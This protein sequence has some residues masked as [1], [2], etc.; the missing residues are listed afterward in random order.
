M[1][2]PV[3][4]ACVVAT[5]LL[6]RLW[7]SSHALHRAARHAGPEAA[8][9]LVAANSSLRR[10][11]DRAYDTA[12]KLSDRAA[13]MD[14]AHE[15]SWGELVF[16][17]AVGAL[18]G[19]CWGYTAWYVGHATMGGDNV[20]VAVFAIGF[21]AL[22]IGAHLS[23]TARKASRPG[24]LEKVGEASARLLKRAAAVLGTAAAIFTT[25]K[26][27]P[28]MPDWG[29]L[30]SIILCELA[31]ALML[32]AIGTQVITRG[33]GP[34]LR[35]RAAGEQRL[36][37][38]LS[39]TMHILAVTLKSSTTEL[40]PTVDL[41]GG[42]SATTSALPPSSPQLRKVLNDDTQAIP[43][44]ES[45]DPGQAEPPDS[46]DGLPYRRVSGLVI[47]AGLGFAAAA[48]LAGSGDA[49]ASEAHVSIR[50][51][52]TASV[53]RPEAAAAVTIIDEHVVA[54]ARESQA[55]TTITLGAWS[56]GS[57]EARSVGDEWIVP[58]FEFTCSSPFRIRCEYLRQ[59]ARQHADSLRAPVIQ[60]FEAAMRD[61]RQRLAFELD[62]S[63]GSSIASLLSSADR[64]AEAGLSIVV[65]DGEQQ[66]YRAPIPICHS[67]GRVVVILVGCR[68]D[69]DGD[70]AARADALRRLGYVVANGLG[71]ARAL[72]WASLLA[73]AAR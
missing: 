44:N 8:R 57:L 17:C 70:G 50:F 30:G 33:P 71:E 36:A 68:F 12:Q 52:T 10:R 19:G 64:D 13:A 39:D 69:R 55:T 32:A 54:G 60:Q 45:R 61:L 11:R 16:W 65:T 51:D 3:I 28:Q 7:F 2:L 37:E 23:V 15:T 63:P 38:R 72:P 5:A 29:G 14:G 62:E 9:D 22:V 56:G 31:L 46:D 35:F 41:V 53:F 24:E 4:V 1:S 25:A 34:L 21:P 49:L 27:V 6:Y 58:G 18:A 26:L 48:A 73:L 66:Y 20:Q 47:A 59:L 43:S 40:W 67:R 42:A